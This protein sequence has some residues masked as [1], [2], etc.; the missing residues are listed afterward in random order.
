[1]YGHVP[2]PHIKHIYIDA[3]CSF[4]CFV[5]FSS[6]HWGYVSSKFCPLIGEVYKFRTGANGDFKERERE[7][8]LLLAA[9]KEM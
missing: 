6:P 1:M 7:I 2:R 8:K 9:A 4:V 5:Y 3:A